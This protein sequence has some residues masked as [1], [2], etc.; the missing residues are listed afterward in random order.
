M[1]KAEAGDNVGL[2]LRG[3]SKDEVRR[4]MLITRPGQVETHRCIECQVYFT[5]QE[6]GGRKKGFYSGYKPQIYL[7]TL[8]VAAEMLLPKNTKVGMPGDNLTVKMRLDQEV[9]VEKG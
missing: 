3:L 6:E 8:D 9:V 2:L 5:T 7:K 4:G 1:D